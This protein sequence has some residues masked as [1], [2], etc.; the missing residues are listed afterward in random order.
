MDH[1]FQRLILLV[2]NHWEAFKL[3][4]CNSPFTPHEPPL[5]E[6]ARHVRVFFREY[7]FSVQEL[8]DNLAYYI[9]DQLE[10]DVQDGSP[11]QVA[12]TLIDSFVALKN[13]QQVHLQFTPNSSAS[14][15]VCDDQYESSDSEDDGIA[16]ETQQPKAPKGPIVDDDGFTLVRRFGPRI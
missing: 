11:H 4:I 12:Q 5:E 13:G 1:E 8:A 10:C 9:Q 2:F 3:A 15:V 7:P 16:A 6:L 14:R